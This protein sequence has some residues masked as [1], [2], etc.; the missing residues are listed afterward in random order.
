MTRKTSH[1]LTDRE[2]QTEK[3]K[4]EREQYEANLETKRVR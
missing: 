2:R 1:R 4:Q 3:D